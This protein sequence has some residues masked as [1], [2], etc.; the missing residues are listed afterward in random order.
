M[1]ETV[2]GIGHKAAS[3]R[4][5]RY[6]GRCRPP[7]G[8]NLTTSEQSTQTKRTQAVPGGRDLT[9]DKSC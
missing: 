2:S 9:L 7:V 1:S 3:V 5:R 8:G 6:T 4:Y